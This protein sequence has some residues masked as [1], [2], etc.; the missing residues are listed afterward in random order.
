VVSGAVPESNNLHR[1][2]GYIQIL[3][4][5]WKKGR[6]M[7]KT[8]GGVRNVA[9]ILKTYSGTCCA[10][11]PVTSVQIGRDSVCNEEWARTSL[12]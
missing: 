7:S 11:K 5:V 10:T 6:E 3:S 2:I 9:R 12:V 4:K 8:R 1:S